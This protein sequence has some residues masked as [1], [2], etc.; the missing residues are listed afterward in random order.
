MNKWPILKRNE[1]A[2]IKLDLTEII[3]A[4]SHI[5]RRT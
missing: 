2:I 4:I 1:P 5:V 3:L